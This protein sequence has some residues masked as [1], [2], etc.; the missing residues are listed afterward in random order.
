MTRG[1]SIGDSL[2]NAGYD[3]A[4]L[5]SL[6]IGGAINLASMASTDHAI[7]M[8]MGR[9][10][11][12]TY[13]SYLQTQIGELFYGLSAAMARPMRFHRAGR[14]RGKQRGSSISTLAE[15]VPR[16]PRLE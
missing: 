5:G 8:K 11:S 15:S 10:L 6:R 2:S 4:R 9:W 3:L 14:K 13:E 7:I 12:N 1:G 16:P